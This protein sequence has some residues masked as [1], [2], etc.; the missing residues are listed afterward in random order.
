MRRLTLTVVLGFAWLTAGCARP[1]A[2]VSARAIVLS[3]HGQNQEAARL[4]EAELL[5]NPSALR[6]R[7]LLI[8]VY[9]V[10][11]DL[12]RAR[13]HAEL[14]A[15]SL[16]V[17]S[18]LPWLDLGHAHELCHRYDEALELYDLAARVAP[19][20]PA[21]P[22]T[23]GMRAAAWGEALLAEP[24]LVEALRRDAGDGRVYHALGLVRVKLGDLEGAQAAYQGGVLRDPRGLDNHLG[25][26][27]L[28]LVKDD[29]PRVLA[30]YDVILQ[31]YPKFADAE[32]GRSWALLRLGRLTEAERALND[33]AEL[34]ASA[35]SLNRQR[36]WLAEERAKSAG[37]R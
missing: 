32:L 37:T 22:R 17:G 36:R 25:L 30:E 21:G 33:A 6:A 18:P 8:R 34:G 27:T 2:D 5:R 26:A 15:R 10:L 7:R 16:G 19:T 4:L 28:A 12:G 20:D 1:H 3:D 24:R 11:G 14:L 13:A 9:G 31:L 35:R 29:A 23:G